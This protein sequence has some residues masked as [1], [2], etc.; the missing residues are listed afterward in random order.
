[1]INDVSADNEQPDVRLVLAPYV[2]GRLTFYGVFDNTSPIPGRN[3]ERS[4]LIQDVSAELPDGPIN[5][6]HMWIQKPFDIDK[7]T[8]LKKKTT[9][10]NLLQQLSNIHGS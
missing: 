9:D 7:L 5:I 1:M 4:S 8:T 10:L 3:L 2:G 6:G